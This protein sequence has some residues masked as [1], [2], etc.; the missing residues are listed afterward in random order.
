MKIQILGSFLFSLKMQ[1]MCSL[2]FILLL[3]VW[4]LCS[5][6]KAK[7]TEAKFN[8]L[9]V[10]K[11]CVIKREWIENGNICMVLCDTLYNVRMNWKWQYLCIWAAWWGW[12]CWCAVSRAWLLSWRWTALKFYTV[13]R[14]MLHCSLQK[15]W[16]VHCFVCSSVSF[17]FFFVRL[18]QMRCMYDIE[19][20]VASM[21]RSRRQ[22]CLFFLF[23]ILIWDN[24]QQNRQ[25]EH[26]LS[27]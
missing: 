3:S 5:W 14:V 12:W 26:F 9:C 19:R 8:K 16:R 21:S 15:L 4:L 1:K 23:V 6:W 27:K 22:I 2:H 24:T 13:Q 20:V 10:Y 7:C 11:V 25:L 17:F 18:F